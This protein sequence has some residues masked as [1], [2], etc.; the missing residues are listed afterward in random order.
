[1]VI[2]M[3]K[4]ADHFQKMLNNSMRTNPEGTD[5]EER[6]KAKI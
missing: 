5:K 4:N 1:M 2:G 3:N 6:E